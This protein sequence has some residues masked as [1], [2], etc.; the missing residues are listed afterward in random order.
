MSEA[1]I[2]R[3]AGSGGIADAFAVIAVTYP[4]GSICTCTN[5]NKLF[6]AK[7]TSGQTLFLIPSAGTWTVSCT[8]GT[9]TAEEVVVVASRYQVAEI[10][11]KYHYWLY[12]KGKEFDAI[13]GGWNGYNGSSYF[14][15]G[16]FQKNESDLDIYKTGKQQIAASPA[17][18]IDLTSFATLSV[19]VLDFT[20]PKANDGLW[21]TIT[22]A[23]LYGDTNIKASQLISTAGRACLDI[24]KITGAFYISVRAASNTGVSMCRF[25]QV[26][27]D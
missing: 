8:D 4:A 18:K 22:T 15:T 20:I 24:S 12:C 25:D 9:E 11:L 13:T 10:T 3:R 5:G 27:L 19:N 14:S 16:K 17:E 1:F 6:K 23:H 26:Y 2:V 21:I 7:D